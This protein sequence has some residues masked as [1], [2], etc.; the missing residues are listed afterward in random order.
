MLHSRKVT[1]AEFDDMIKD[2]FTLISG[3][4]VVE[5]ANQVDWHAQMAEL[6]PNGMESAG[7]YVYTF[8]NEE[9]QVVGYAWCSDKEDSMR[10]IAYIGVKEAFRRRGYAIQIIEEICRDAKQAGVSVMALGVEK[11]NL[12]AIHLYERNGF[13]SVGEEDIRFIMVKELSER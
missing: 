5:G 10:L 1:E 2:C 7:N 8:L 4:S 11:N 9:E 3:Y 13:H 12:P 6:L